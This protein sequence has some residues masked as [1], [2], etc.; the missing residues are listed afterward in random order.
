MVD[1]VE[2]FA[3]DKR[4]EGASAAWQDVGSKLFLSESVAETI[5]REWRRDILVLDTGLARPLP[6]GHASNGKTGRG[7]GQCS[8]ACCEGFGLPWIMP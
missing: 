1:V 6:S 5:D 2:E 8:P 3:G 4:P 7:G